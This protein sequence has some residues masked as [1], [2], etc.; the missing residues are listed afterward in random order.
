MA[1]DFLGPYAADNYAAVQPAFP[2]G[3][4]F[5]VPG[6]CP[7]LANPTAADTYGLCWV[8]AGFTCTGGIMWASDIDTGTEALDIDIGWKANGG[9]GTYDTVDTDGLGNLGVW[10]G[11]AFATGNINVVSSNVYVFAGAFLSAG[12]W[13]AFTRKTLIRAYCNVTA[14]AFTAGRISVNVFGF[15]DP[16]IAVG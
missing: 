1:T 9:S 14:N 16:S 6:T 12:I 3:V 8:P 15:V 11:D 5:I 10:N 13:P 7:V 4:G 2:K